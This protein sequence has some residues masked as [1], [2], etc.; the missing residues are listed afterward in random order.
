MSTFV[1]I[2]VNVPSL[3]GVFD[4]SLPERLAGRVGVGQLVEAPFG[5]QTVQGVILRFIDGPSISQTKEI[6]EVIDPQ[7]VLTSAQ[8]AFAES[9]A[10]STFSPLAA[11]VALFLPPGLSH[12]AD[13]LFA[14]RE[15]GE[16]ENSRSKTPD[17]PSLASRLVKLLTGR[18]RTWNGGKPH[19]FWSSAAS[20]ARNPFYRR[21]V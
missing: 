15:S 7:P 10:E 8:I 14:I 21:R 5:I 1:Q 9:L 16:K 19:R 11:I 18:Y 6:N 12:Q 17:L 4:Y 3:A 13:T 2:A 20:L